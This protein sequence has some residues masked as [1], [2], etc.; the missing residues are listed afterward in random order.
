[1]FE[2]PVLSAAI[3]IAPGFDLDGPI[4]SIQPYG[5]GHINDT[6]RVD[7]AAGASYILQRISPTAFP[8]P[9]QVMENVV[10]VTGHLRQK[11]VARGG[12]PYRETL[13]PVA[14]SSGTWWITDPDG[15][16]WRM[17]L[18]VTDAVSYDLP[19]NTE[20]M[21]EAGRAFGAFAATLSDFPAGLLH[22]TITKFHDTPDRLRRF[23]EVLFSDPA[24]R[25]AGVSEEIA[26]I[27]SR[28]SR[29]GLLLAGL[30]N[31]DYPLRVTH[32]DTKVNNVLLDRNTGRAVCVIDLDTVMPGL[33]AYDFGDAIRTGASTAAEDEPDLSRVHFRPDMYRA[34][35][36]GY[37][38]EAGAV[39]EEAEL[40]S[41]AEGAWTMT[42]ENGVRFLTDYL[43]GDHYYHT[44]YPDHN[45]VRARNQFALLKDFERHE[46]EMIETVLELGGNRQ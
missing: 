21:R 27:E 45:L 9:G 1:M 12:N 43:D 33:S 22:E 30:H 35:C 6:F 39:M 8:D 4:E 14:T 13:T 11:I 46:N 41:L 19:D 26:F 25:S 23:R 40:R 16:G 38:P 5:S 15:N 44:A 28:A 42:Y 7:T 18:L 20:I 29:A 2:N 3:K 17:Y 10:R 31:G 36:E 37:L 34:W 32:N 24:G